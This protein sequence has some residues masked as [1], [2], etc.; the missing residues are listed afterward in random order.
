MPWGEDITTIGF[1]VLVIPIFISFTILPG[2]IYE[3]GYKY[4]WHGFG[5]NQFHYNMFLGLTLGL[6]P[7]YIFFKKYDPILKEYFRN[8]KKES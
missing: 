4:A 2:I 8:N 3:D 7:I 1:L 6:G 5:K